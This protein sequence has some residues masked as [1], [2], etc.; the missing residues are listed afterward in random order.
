M[1]IL[2]DDYL[3]HEEDNP[4]LGLKK[5]IAVAVFNASLIFLN[6][7]LLN[8]CIQYFEPIYIIPMK[9]VALLTNNILC[10]GIILKEFKEYNV[11]MALGIG[12]GV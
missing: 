5:T 12:I 6:L 11:Y 3:H 8:K 10:G 7:F 4:T 9:K 1:N 2:H